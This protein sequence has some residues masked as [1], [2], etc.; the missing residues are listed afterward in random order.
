MKQSLSRILIVN[1]CLLLGSFEAFACHGVALVNYSVTNTGSSITVNG[2]SDPAT[3]GC[4]PYYME[5]ELACFSSANFTGN[6]PACT[7]GTWGT[8]PWYH[9][10]LNVPNYTAAAGWP[11]NCATEPYNTVTIPFSGLCSGTTYVLRSRE[12]VC[13]GTNGPWSSTYTFTTP[14]TPPAYNITTNAAPSTIC[15]GQQSVLTCTINGAGGCG[16]G[17][18]TITWNPGNLSGATVTVTPTTTTVYTVTATGGYLTCYGSPPATVT[19]TVLPPPVAGTA[20]ISPGTVCQG[21]CAT[22][23]LTGYTGNV[24]WQSSPNGVTWTNIAGATTTPYTYC[25][26]NAAMYFRASVA[27]AAG[28]GTVYS[29][30][31]TINITPV[32][33]LT[34]SPNNPSICVGQSQVLNVTGSSNYTWA[35]PGNPN[36]GTGSSLSV[37]PAS[38]TTYTVTANASSACPATQTV[39]VTVNPLPVITFNPSSPA[40]CAGESITIDAGSSGNTYVWTPTSGLTFL[41]ASQ[42]SVSASPGTTTSYN[43]TATTAAGCGTSAVITVTVNPTPVL[44]LSANPVTICPNSS[45]TVTISGA[46]NYSWTPLTGATVL[47]PN[48]SQVE[49]TPAT[50]TTYTVTGTTAAGCVDSTT[51]QVNVTNNIVVDAGLPDS[52]CPGQSAT[53]AANGG[54]IYNWTSN[55]GATINNANTSTPTVTPSVTTIFTVNVANQFG[56]TGVDSVEV[57][58]Y[59]LPLPNAG[60]DTALCKGA[61]ITLNGSGGGVYAW[62]GTPIISGAGS[63]NPLINPIV[64]TNYILTVIDANG[65]QAADTVNVVVHQLPLASAGADQTIC[66]TNC[67]SLN[68]TGGTVYSWLP[69]TNLSSPNTAATQ[70]CPSSTT[71]YTVTV[72]D[73][74]GCVNED[75]VEVIVNP[76]LQVLASNPASICPGSQTT[77]SAVGSGGDG[78]P[79]TYSWSPAAGLGTPNASSTTASPTITTTYVVTVTDNCGSTAVTASVVVTVFALPVVSV[80]PDQTEGCDPVCVN[81]AGSSNPAAASCTYSFGDLTSGTNCNESHCYTSP[82]SYTI[83]Y[84][85]TDLNGCVNSITYPNMIVVHPNPVAGFTVSPQTT[86]II[87]PEITFTPNCTNCDTTWYYPGDPNDSSLLG[88]Q[89]IP[90]TYEYTS[91]GTY[92]ITQVVTNQWGCS[93]TATEY[94]VIEPDWSFFAP[95][96]F[97]PNFDNRNET[98]LVYGEG[99]DNSNFQMWVFDR[100]GNMI[101]TSTDINKGWDGTRDGG[102]LAQIDTYV[103]RVQFKDI[104][105]DRH[106]FTGHVSL[107]R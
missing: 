18:P 67:A 107:I 39:T 99:I 59:P 25:P 58:V 31:V 49:F 55:T 27:S 48:G 60:P 96:A 6:A 42:D 52:L 95:N 93:D 69:L 29:N 12:R 4:G 68:A 102:E 8:Y 20:S 92:Y 38:T 86:S 9:S 104:N 34:I 97:T 106:T 56:C 66:G 24:Q 53:L 30:I 81:F 89:V 32:P 22:L 105:G 103:W 10:L 33:T 40:I 37:S 79:Y 88:P 78:G 41:S 3:C 19:V 15:S 80:I 90:Y 87:A 16:S 100:W 43:V 11:D 83:T 76:A 46:A 50:S 28:C 23:T 101:F 64:T 13:A 14:G 71:T 62:T 5:V 21:G 45:D 47:T 51:L 73:Q 85:V 91:A 70:A 17:N 82:G 54:T 72:S 98:F 1:C 7:A 57:F 61:A 65:C 94:V 2:S 63:P 84:T 44:V 35:G 36:L 74:F 75:S 77:I 26:I